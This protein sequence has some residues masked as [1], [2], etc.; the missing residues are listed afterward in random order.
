MPA[1]FRVLDKSGYLSDDFADS[2]NSGAQGC[3]SAIIAVNDNRVELQQLLTRSGS[4]LE[5]MLRTRTTV[6]KL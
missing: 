2:N 6:R 1:S 4:G 5:A 3:M